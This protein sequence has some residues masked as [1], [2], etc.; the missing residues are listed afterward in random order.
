MKKYLFDGSYYEISYIKEKLE[1]YEKT[2]LDKSS[3]YYDIYKL[4]NKDLI[5]LDYGCGFGVFSK[6][7]FNRFVKGIN[8]VSPCKHT[9]CIRNER[10]RAS[11]YWY[12]A[13]TST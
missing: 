3:R 4:I 6:I 1:T 10:R 8:V 5:G 7:D 2:I 12:C 11:K 13:Q 9:T